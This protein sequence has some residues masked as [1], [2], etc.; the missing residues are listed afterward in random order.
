MKPHIA[1]YGPPNASAPL[2]SAAASGKATMTIAEAATRLGLSI[3]ATRKAALAGQVPAIR[4][5]RRWLVLR[6]PLEAMLAGAGA[7]DKE[8][9]L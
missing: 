6:D 4:I 2:R 5:G 1:L 8:G 3:K 7:T 9:G